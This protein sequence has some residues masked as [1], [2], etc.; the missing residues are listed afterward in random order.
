MNIRDIK[1][2]IELMNVRSINGFAS[3]VRGAESSANVFENVARE[4]GRIA[5]ETQEH[6]IAN[7]LVDTG[8]LR[9]SFTK[10]DED[11][12]PS[13]ADILHMHRPS[14]WQE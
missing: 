4:L 9:R 2:A 12:T 10:D 3:G 8:Y 5:R 11:G 6:I 13:G 1:P 7:S 14:S